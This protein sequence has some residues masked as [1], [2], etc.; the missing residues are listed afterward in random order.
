MTTKNEIELHQTTLDMSATLAPKINSPEKGKLT[1]DRDAY[2][3]SLKAIEV[4]I[5]TV[6]KIEKHNKIYAAGAHYAAGERAIEQFKENPDL[7]TVDFVASTG[8]DARLEVGYKR[9]SEEFTSPPRKD[10]NGVEI[11]RTKEMRYC[12]SLP[13]IVGPSN[14]QLKQVSRL[15][16]SRA[17]SILKPD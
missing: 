9:S 4:D 1:L 14:T 7:E 16:K 15:L 12:S 5:D 8:W 17:A 6:K 13:K 3:E 11:E 10:E 2:A